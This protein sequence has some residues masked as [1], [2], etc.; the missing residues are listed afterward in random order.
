MKTPGWWARLSE[1][2]TA[3]HAPGPERARRIFVWLALAFSACV[4]IQVFLLG[5]QVFGAV[6]SDSGLH[7]DFAYLYGWLLPL[8]LIIGRIGRVTPPT[9][10]LTG[11]ALVLYALQTVLPAFIKQL[12]VLGPLHAINALV[13]FGLGLWLAQRVNS[14]TPAGDR[15]P[16]GAGREV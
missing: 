13:L 10:V 14:E 15:S 7:R 1:T 4:V 2:E 3:A 9:L 5:L 11:L 16:G 6:S 8:M 12:P